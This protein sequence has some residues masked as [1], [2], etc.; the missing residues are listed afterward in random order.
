LERE[1]SEVLLKTGEFYRKNRIYCFR[2]ATEDEKPVEIAIGEKLFTPPNPVQK[3]ILEAWDNPKYKVFTATG[4]NRIGKTTIECIIG[5][6]VLYG[7]WPWSGKKI[8]FSHRKA[9][10]VRWVGQAWESHIKAVIIPALRTWWPNSRPVETKKNNQG[11]EYLWKDLF[12]GSVIEIM[13]NAQDSDMFEGWEGDLVIYDEPPKRDIR[14]ACARGLIDRNGRELFGAT[15]LK[16]AWIHREIIKARLENGQPDDSVFNVYGQIYDN[17]GYGLTMEG[18]NQFSKSL[19]PEEKE[20]RLY[21]KPS[22]MSSLVFPKFNR[23]LHIKKPFKIPLDWI[24][25]LSI[26]FHPSKPWAVVFLATAKNNFKYV[27]KE[28]E[29]RGNP[30]FVG[31]EIIRYVKEGNLRVG[32]ATIDPLSKGD[33]NAHEDAQTVF[34]ILSQTLGS[35]NIMLD[36]ASKDKDNGISLVNNL[37]WTENEMPGIF[38]FEDCIKTIQQVE[39]LM[40]DPESLKPTALKIEDDFTECLYRLALLNTQWFNEVNF[41]ISEQRSMML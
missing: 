32:K 39:D 28:F 13:S 11:I 38:F 23:E 19:K 25:D 3:Q 8:P 35:V 24:V 29:I 4:A 5:E 31:E 17:V 18:V 14:V 37:L 7:E 22:Y 9:R 36:V 20:A 41:N 33:K 34:D 30:K 15:L 10:K 21:G 27:C 26:D 40:Y 2:E 1:Y 6:S 12:T 16:E